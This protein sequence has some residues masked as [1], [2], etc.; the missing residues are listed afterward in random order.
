M[1]EEF[2]IRVLVPMSY[3]NFWNYIHC[4]SRRQSEATGSHGRPQKDPWRQSQSQSQPREVLIPTE[5]S[6]AGRTGFKQ[7][8]AIFALGTPIRPKSQN[9][10]NVPLP[11]LAS[12]SSCAFI[13]ATD[14]D[15]L[16]PA[17]CIK[18]KLHLEIYAILLLQRLASRS[19]C[20]L[21]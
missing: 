16:L 19:S 9:P 6:G 13:F 10:L 3:L 20:V 7:T 14:V 4:P 2:D 18:Y 15:E 5:R 17:A 11:R 1:V 8:P 12:G 21:I